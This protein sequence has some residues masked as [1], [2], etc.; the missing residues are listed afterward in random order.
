MSDFQKKT[1]DISTQ[2]LKHHY[3]STFLT[4]SRKSSIILTT[5]PCDQID[6]SSR[7]AASLLML[8]MRSCMIGLYPPIY[9][10]PYL[11]IIDN[12]TWTCL[13]MSLF[14]RLYKPRLL[15]TTID[16][17]LR[18]P[19]L[20][21]T[22]QPRFPCQ[23]DPTLSYERRDIPM[24]RAFKTVMYHSDSTKPPSRS[25]SKQSMICYQK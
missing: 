18:L 24:T 4:T 3:Q 2:T 5:Q 14:Q 1:D 10:E 6:A 8:L 22:L 17:S 15:M 11:N 19:S 12:G 7:L 21:H 23:H 16:T 9:S 13:V 25:H 20:I